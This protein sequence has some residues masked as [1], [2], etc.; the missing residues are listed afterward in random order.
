MNAT[1]WQKID[2]WARSASPFILSVFLVILSIVPIY[3][4][5]YDRISPVFVLASIYHWAVYRPDL[6]P[7]LAVFILGVF[8]DI[9]LGTPMGLYVLVFLTVYGI[10]L[11][12]RRFL[13]GKSFVIY[14]FG[15][16]IILVLASV[17]SWIIASILNV[18]VLEFGSIVFQYFL[19]LGIFPI[20][21]W[22]FLRWQQS[23]LN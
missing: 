14:W 2:H 5:D 1:F 11:S 10:V 22:L 7:L 17:E 4:P 6:L 12:Q 15:F 23:F 13:V 20:M 3:A 9:F 8:Q 21:A 18:T 19:F 16:S